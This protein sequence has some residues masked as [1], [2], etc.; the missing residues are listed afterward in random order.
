MDVH[1]NI[2][3]H[4]SHKIILKLIF[5]WG[6]LFVFAGTA[7]IMNMGGPVSQVCAGRIDDMN[8]TKSDPLNDPD[9]TCTVQ[10]N[11]SA[12]LGADTVGLIYGTFIYVNIFQ[13]Y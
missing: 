13:Y 7:S 9:G 5:S 8:G 10:G 11:C 1:F 6:D 12:P 3:A 2:F 4:V